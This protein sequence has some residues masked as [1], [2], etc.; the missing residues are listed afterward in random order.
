VFDPHN[1]LGGI[2]PYRVYSLLAGPTD[3]DD[4][5]GVVIAERLLASL[6]GAIASEI[7]FAATLE[8]VEDYLAHHEIN[9]EQVVVKVKPPNSPKVADPVWVSKQALQDGVAH[10]VVESP[11]L[12]RLELVLMVRF[13]TIVADMLARA[14]AT[15]DWAGKWAR[16]EAGSGVLD[17]VVD[18]MKQF[19]VPDWRTLLERPDEGDL[20]LAKPVKHL[21]QNV[22]TASPLTDFDTAYVTRGFLSSPRLFPPGRVPVPPG[23]SAP[24]LAATLRELDRQAIDYAEVSIGG[25][26]VLTMLDDPESRRVLADSAVRIGWLVQ[27]PN[28]QIVQPDNA[29][30]FEASR[31]AVAAALARPEVAGF[32]VLAPELTNYGISPPTVKDRLGQLFAICNELA[33]RRVV[34]HIHVGEGGPAWNLPRDVRMDLLLGKR[35]KVAPAVDR[36]A[37]EKAKE[38][39]RGNVTAILDGLPDDIAP[40]VRVRF[41]HVTH[42]GDE[43]AARMTERGVWADVNLTS[44][45]STSAWFVGGEVD[46]KRVDPR[47]YEGHGVY[48]LAAAGV[49]FVLGT[50]GSG[51]EHSALTV[52]YAV[53]GELAK[54]ESPV[55]PWVRQSLQNSAEHTAWI[56]A[57]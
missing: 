54:L 34:A 12:A 7:G 17:L 8:D 40:S 1:H 24:T 36:E 26:D 37:T 48:A 11:A 55:P 20:A 19:H 49:P 28:P 53:L 44:N 57:A 35:A 10:R 29:A 47:L 14:R 43:Q 23:T 13:Y 39:A 16:I 27:I 15:G 31:Q 22:F 18:A 32:T 6:G 2:L 4:P 5:G 21:L 56:A 50:D 25:D 41:G 38:V 33:P 45:I 51:V 9:R 52:E 3:D 46:V 30:A 42:A